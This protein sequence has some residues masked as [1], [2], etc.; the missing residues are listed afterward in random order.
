MFPSPSCCQ[1]PMLKKG[2]LLSKVFLLPGGVDF[3]VRGPA[4]QK[5]G[6]IFKVFEL[7]KLHLI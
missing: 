3:Q 5:S 7:H 4:M 1:K 6:D 2:L